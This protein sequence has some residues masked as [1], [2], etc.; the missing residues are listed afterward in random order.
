MKKLDRLQ[1]TLNKNSGDHNGNNSNQALFG[2]RNSGENV[3]FFNT[4][5]QALYALPVFRQI[6]VLILSNIPGANS[7]RSLFLEIAQ[8][9]FP[10]QTS[11]FI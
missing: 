6:L 9:E 10:V 4:I 3:C 2:L 1:C 5:I 7:I 8:S 11:R